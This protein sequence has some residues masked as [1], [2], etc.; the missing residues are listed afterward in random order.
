[1]VIAVSAGNDRLETRFPRHHHAS[2]TRARMG[3]A[4]HSN[5]QLIPDATRIV[6]RRTLRLEDGTGDD[7]AHDGEADG[8]RAQEVEELN[9]KLDGIVSKRFKLKRTPTGILPDEPHPSK[10]RKTL[11]EERGMELFEFRHSEPIG[12]LAP[13]CLHGSTAKPF[14][15]PSVWYQRPCHPVPFIYALSPLRLSRK[16]LCTVTV[17]D[18]I[19]SNNC[20]QRRGTVL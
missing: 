20:F 2:A 9:A 16:P 18:G 14:L 4:K 8:M 1:M 17:F 3:L 12:E 7:V 10:K 5:P 19:R 6:S 11:A 15:E 13:L